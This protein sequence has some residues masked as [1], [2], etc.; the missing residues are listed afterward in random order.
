MRMEEFKAKTTEEAIAAGDTLAADNPPTEPEEPSPVADVL[1]LDLTAEQRNSLNMLNYLTVLVQEIN[2]S[3]NSRLLMEQIYSELL[4]NTTPSIDSATTV[5]LLSI[6]D[7]IESYRMTDVKRE[8]L[9]YIFEQGQ[10]QAIAA[11][12]PDPL[13]LL[14]AVQS[15]NPIDLLASVVYMAVD[16]ATSYNSAMSQ[17][18]LQYLQENWALDDE[19]A[20]TLHESRKS[21]FSYAVRIVGDYELPAFLT[22]NETAIDQFVAWKNM[23]NVVRRIELLESSLETYQALGPYWLLLAESYYANGDYEK[24][25]SAVETYETLATDILRKDYDYAKVLTLAIVAA[26]ETLSDTEYVELASRYASEILHNCDYDDWALRYFVAQ[27]YVDLYATSGDTTYL[28]KAYDTALDNASYL[29]DEQLAMNAA[30]LAPVVEAV[31]PE[32]ATKEAKSEI[33]DY[34]KMLKEE[35]KTE[36]APVYE[37]LLL[38]CQLLFALA[39]RL[40]ISNTEQARIDAMLHGDGPLFLIE[41]LNALYTFGSTESEEDAD[42]D[43]AIVFTGKELRLPIEM[44]SEHATIVVT[45]TS[46]TGTTTFSDWT[47]KKVERGTKEEIDTF[48][49]V[50]ASESSS[51]FDYKVGMQVDISIAAYDDQAVDSVEVALQT[52]DTKNHW[53]ETAMVWDAGIGFV[54]E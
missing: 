12:V 34:N 36:L 53:W 48:V 22:L 50:Y 51:K 44:I 5:E 40:D 45:V 20:T 38:N 42:E 31:A 43:G 15:R 39:D 26:G 35:R 33:D 32:G 10:A 18:E 29:V 54:E 1:A 23:P 30:F 24:C 9:Q 4:N 8:R 3:S 52:V 46:D 21:S 7:T 6:L 2:E 49:A 28:Q 27:T 14:S 41:S 11:A 19:Q 16:S 17:A 47:I 13:A 37:P 25:L